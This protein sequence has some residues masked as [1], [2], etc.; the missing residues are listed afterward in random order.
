MKTI[1]NTIFG[2]F[3]DEGAVAAVGLA[4]DVEQNP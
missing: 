3:C 1:S 4:F 2:G